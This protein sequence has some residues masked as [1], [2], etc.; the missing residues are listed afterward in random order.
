MPSRRCSSEPWR[1][2]AG[3]FIDGE[4]FDGWCVLAGL[5]PTAARERLQQR[6]ARR[7]LVMG[8]GMISGPPRD[9]GAA[10]S[11][12]RLS[13]EQVTD[14][15]DRD[16]AHDYGRGTSTTVWFSNSASSTSNNCRNKASNQ[17]TRQR[18]KQAERNEP[19][20]DQRNSRCRQPDNSSVYEPIV[21]PDAPRRGI[22]ARR[23]GRAPRSEAALVRPASW[24]G[25]GHEATLVAAFD[26]RCA[27]GAPL[28]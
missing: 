4:D 2:S 18:G 3:A 11:S 23:P 28:S 27:R 25:Q 21:L 7:C 8:G 6:S 5:N 19:E 22:G 17:E 24:I 12:C 9:P 20:H 26:T 14:N 10:L 15:Q 1:R 13:D 16:V